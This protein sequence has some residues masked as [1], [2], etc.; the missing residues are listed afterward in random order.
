MPGEKTEN[1]GARPP[2]GNE[3]YYTV[4]HEIKLTPGQQ[5]TL[6]PNTLHW[7]QGG[8][9]GAIVSEFSTTSRDESDIFTDPRIKRLPEV[10]G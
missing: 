6:M 8:P 9:E 2:Q 3:A 10:E 5:Y 7:F 1:P 4:F